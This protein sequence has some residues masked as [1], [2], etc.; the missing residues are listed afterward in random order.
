[1]G[2]RS[3]RVTVGLPA[4]L[5]AC[6]HTLYNDPDACSIDP[7]IACA[8]PLRPNCVRGQCFSD[9]ELPDGATPVD[10]SGLNLDGAVSCSN[11]GTRPDD[12][13]VCQASMCRPCDNNISDDAQCTL[14]NSGTPRCNIADGRCVQCLVSADCSAGMP[15]CG[16]D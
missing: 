16:T 15:V 8:D 14:H 13:P 6:F 4:L 12:A 9:Q 3:L 7:P 11:S 10:F 5:G 2:R 1:M